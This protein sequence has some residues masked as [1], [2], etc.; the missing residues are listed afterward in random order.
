MGTAIVA[1]TGS[2]GNKRAIPSP[3][4]RCRPSRTARS[5]RLRKADVDGAARL[6]VGASPVKVAIYALTTGRL[7]GQS[8]NGLRARK[9][10]GA[11][12]IASL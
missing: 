1:V 11:T 4:F 6:D 3:T 12:L 7:S 2:A 10:Y 5:A 9:L 8:E